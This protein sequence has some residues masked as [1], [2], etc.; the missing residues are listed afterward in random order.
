M[1]NDFPRNND[2]DDTE[3]QYSS[4]RSLDRDRSS[5][6]KRGQREG[7]FKRMFEAD[8]DEEESSEKPKKRLSKFRKTF[9]KLFQ[10]S[11]VTPPERIFGSTPEDNNQI[12]KESVI[13]PEHFG[14]WLK[15]MSGGEDVDDH[16]PKDTLESNDSISLDEEVVVD[17]TNTPAEEVPKLDTER[18][19]STKVLDYG[20]RQETVDDN[21]IRNN[22]IVPSISEPES[23]H[24]II[25][26]QTAGK[27]YRD[28]SPMDATNA[29][30]PT[31]RSIHNEYYINNSSWGPALIVDHLSRGRDRKINRKQDKIRDD[32]SVTQQQLKTI[33][34][35]K[36]NPR[37][38]YR[39]SI[40]RNFQVQEIQHNTETI[41]KPEILD[42]IVTKD[43]KLTQKE[44]KIPHLEKK[45]QGE[46][47][48]SIEKNTTNNILE[49]TVKFA[50][51]QSSLIERE[52]E[53][54]HEIKD[55]HTYNQ[56]AEK[57]IS[58]RKRNKYY[59]SQ[60]EATQLIASSSVPKYSESDKN[61]KS[62]LTLY[63]QAARNG[64]IIAI[65]ILI[66]FLV[67]YTVSR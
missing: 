45:Q 4:S 17:L 13:P 65:A 6:I 2:Q 12:I 47:S 26:R 63:K 14:D 55:K 3:S 52:H 46:K 53:K 15:K 42:S 41:P 44:N 34:N 8:D 57:A 43:E 37:V 23:V 40:N 56:I 30:K 5:F 10:N 39:D 27:I 50:E 16:Q 64:F 31:D 9:R 20:D 62:D 11:I 18:V 48:N 29:I 32:L 36:I 49:K 33:E 24:Q 51:K 54:R 19:P 22:E 21:A 28:G 66:A 60:T 59:P 38:E 67:I 35:T 25:E 1:E 61:N 58:T 7:L